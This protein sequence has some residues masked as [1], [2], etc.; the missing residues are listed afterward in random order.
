M[1]RQYNNTQNRRDSFGYIIINHK[2]IP[3]P[4]TV[5]S[6]K[7][8][9]FFC[10]LRPVAVRGQHPGNIPIG[11]EHRPELIANLFYNNPATWWRICET[12]NIFDVFEQLNPGDRIFLP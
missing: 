11:Y 1:P 8:E 5:G 10:G 3:I 7:Y 12:N 6:E 4:T 2:G 9:S